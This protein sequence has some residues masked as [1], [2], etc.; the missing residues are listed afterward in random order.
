MEVKK[1]VIDSNKNIV[2]LQVAGRI[3]SGYL[4]AT[5]S[6]LNNL[7]G[8]RPVFLILDLTGLEAIDSTGI[9]LLIKART[10]I[11]QAG[12][13][14]VLLARGRVESVIKLSGLEN[15]FKMAGT[16]EEAIELLNQ[17]PE[18]TATSGTES[19]SEEPQND[20]Q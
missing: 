3:N 16:Q 11:V 9:G 18:P 5:E 8:D 15:Y 20:S 17:P 6:E 19:S 4:S 7:S 13:N 1:S 10:D 14:V 2:S 12:G